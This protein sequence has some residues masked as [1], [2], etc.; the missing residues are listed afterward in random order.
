MTKKE[1]HLLE[2]AQQI[3]SGYYKLFCFYAGIDDFKSKGFLERR[4]VMAYSVVCKLSTETLDTIYLRNK[5]NDLLV[6]LQKARSLS[7]ESPFFRKRSIEMSL[8]KDIENVM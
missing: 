8:I 1:L 7:L 2:V 5:R 3:M 6:H 4:D